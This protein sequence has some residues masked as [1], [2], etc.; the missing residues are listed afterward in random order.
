MQGI[1]C[2]EN[3]IN[4]KKYVGR[5]V[6]IDRRRDQH[7]YALMNNF[8]G[9]DHLQSSYNKYNSDF[10]FYI[11]EIIESKDDLNTRE[12]YWISKLGTFDPSKGY[13]KTQGGEGMLGYTPS[14]YTRK[15]LSDRL[16]GNQY[17][18]DHKH[19]DDWKSKMS[20]LLKGRVVS[21]STRTKMSNSAK[22]KVLSDSTR[23]KISDKLS[24]PNHPM[25][26][27]HLSDE[28][29]R[30]LS[31]S[32]T[33]KVWSDESKATRSKLYTGKGN[34][35]YGK[36]GNLGKISITNGIES[37]YINP[38][39]IDYWRS[40]G[41][42]KGKLESVSE[43]ISSMRSKYLYIIDNHKFIGCSKAIAYIRSL[44]Y[45]KFSQSSLDKLVA[46]YPVRGYSE[47]FNKIIKLEYDHEDNI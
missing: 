17:F 28:T 22:G 4:H 44:G 42:D 8:H 12:I 5:S 2:I 13:N 37:R 7:F 25:Y 20:N 39:E 3:N 15:L 36:P 35:N 9:N 18:L 34:P 40:L 38:E 46:G 19:T 10:S 16:K 1:Y 21:E 43:N 29:K 31:E 30:K 14:E 24:G 33:G 11:L 27:K 26:G 45:T 41:Y 23:K 32:L 6:D 47:L